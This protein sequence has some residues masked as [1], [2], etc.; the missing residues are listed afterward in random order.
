MISNSDDFNERVLCGRTEPILKYIKNCPYARNCSNFFIVAPGRRWHVKKKKKKLNQ[1]YAR[2]LLVRLLSIV[3]LKVKTF[4]LAIPLSL[5]AL[6]HS[7]MA[8]P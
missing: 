2:L 4:F 6:D 1:P 7:I 8:P 3:L 5:H